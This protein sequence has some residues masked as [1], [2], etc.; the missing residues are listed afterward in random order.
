MV[1]AS[2][3]V[4]WGYCGLMNKFLSG[5]KVSQMVATCK[6]EL[7]VEDLGREGLVWPNS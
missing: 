7:K 4:G 6:V 1:R 5:C 3:L 2:E